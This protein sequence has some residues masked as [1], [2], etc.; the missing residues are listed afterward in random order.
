MNEQDELRDE[1]EARWGDPRRCPVHG[2]V[3]SSP[4]GM[5]DC[6]CWECEGE[7]EY[8]AECDNLEAI[9]NCEEITRQEMNEDLPF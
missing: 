4:D 1:Y 3:T 5:H 9:A 8:E 6:P 2:C 7:A